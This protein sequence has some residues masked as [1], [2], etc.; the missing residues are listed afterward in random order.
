M[1]FE[2]VS[3]EWLEKTLQFTVDVAAHEALDEGGGS[4]EDTLRRQ[5]R[6][7]HQTARWIAELEPT[8]R[9]ALAL[10]RLE[11]EYHAVTTAAATIL[12]TFFAVF[13][14][15]AWELGYL[16]LTGFF[17]A[18][19]VVLAMVAVWNFFQWWGVRRTMQLLERERDRVSR[20]SLTLQTSDDGGNG[21]GDDDVDC[22]DDDET[23]A[24]KL[25]RLEQR[26]REAVLV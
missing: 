16:V 11:R 12:C 10:G 15:S 20:E 6:V 4:E 19:G 26:R 21:D 18:L 24:L 22:G 5:Q 7:V 3:E 13:S 2:S 23:T 17:I 9:R 14:A 1:D 8:F 25:R